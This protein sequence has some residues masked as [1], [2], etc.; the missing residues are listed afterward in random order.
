MTVNNCTDEIIYSLLVCLLKSILLTPEF[1]PYFIDS[2]S[3]NFTIRNT[4]FEFIVGLVVNESDPE[5]GSFVLN[6]T[7]C[8]FHVDSIRAVFSGGARY[9]KVR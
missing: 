3:G 1:R 4:S 7:S 9:H 8:S 6:L 5:T 2:G